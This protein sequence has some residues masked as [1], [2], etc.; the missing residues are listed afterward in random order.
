MQN[1][2]FFPATST[3]AGNCSDGFLRLRSGTSALNGRVELCLNNAWG[4]ICD[5]GFGTDDATVICRQLGFADTSKQEGV[6]VL[7]TVM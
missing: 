7:C 1:L 3:A 6:C 4:T 2:F 5:R